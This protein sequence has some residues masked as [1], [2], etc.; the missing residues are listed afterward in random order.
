MNRLEPA[1]DPAGPDEERLVES[2]DGTRIFCAVSGPEPARARGTVLLCHP[3]FSSHRLFEP[4]GWA[5]LAGHR[6]VRWDYRGHGRSD[7][8]TDPAGYSLEHLFEDLEA[9]WA[10]TCGS[11]AIHLGGLSFGGTLAM[12][13]ALREPERVRSLL[14]FN[15]G[16]GFRKPEAAA[17][18][19]EML[20]RSAAKLERVGMGGYLEGDRAR[21]ELLGLDPDRP[22]ARRLREAMLAS[23]PKA[24][25]GFARRVA[26]PVPNL[27]DRLAE[28]AAPSLVIVGERDAAF[29]PASRVLE[30]KLG[31]AER[32]EIPAAGHVVNLDQPEAFTRALRDFLA[33]RA[34]DAE[35]Y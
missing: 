24:L 19:A 26:G 34:Q 25:A 35:R 20:E 15:T 12:A 31:C 1:A 30:A 3:S 7:A 11:E 9:V 2:R 23:D 33:A 18:W 17:Q 22:E 32:I 21:A 8:P 10:A 6:L 27:V 4:L 16:P 28:I 14:L 5:G 29:Q 13:Y